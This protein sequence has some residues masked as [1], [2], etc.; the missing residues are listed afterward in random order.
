MNSMKHYLPLLIFLLVFTRLSILHAEESTDPALIPPKI[1]RP[2]PD[3]YGDNQRM[4]QGIPSVTRSAG[5]RLWATWYTGGTT[6][7]HLNYVLL[8]TSGDDGETWRE[9]LLAVDPDGSGPIRAFDPA[10][11]TDP[12]GRVWLFWAQGASW[13]DGRGGVWAM[14]CDEPERADAQWS[15]PRRLCDGIMMCRPIVDSKGRWLFPATV[16][17]I[18]PNSIASLAHDMG[19]LDGAN[20]MVS[21][22]EGKTLSLLGQARTPAGQNTFNEHMLVERKDGSFWML[23]R[24]KYGIG[25]AT[26]T[27]GG[28]TWSDVTPSALA[29][30]SARFFIHRLNSG[31]LLLVKHGRIK[32]RIGRSHLTAYLS[33][34]EGKTWP[35]SLML[36]ERTGVSYP[37]GVQD[38]DG[39][40]FVIYDY[41]RTSAKQILMARFTEKDIIAGRLVDDSSKL[42]LLVNQATGNAPSKK[43]PLQFTPNKNADAAVM[44]KGP[45]PEIE[46]V[47]EK[48]RVMD[49]TQG[50]LLFH[51]R[52]YRAAAIPK[53]LADREFLYSGIDGTTELIC[54]RPGVLYILTPE[55][56]RNRDSVV[57]QITRQGFER[58]RLSEFLLFGN[59]VG[60]ICT[61]YQKNLKEGERVIMGKWGVAVW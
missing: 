37:D 55:R 5:G 56:S 26:S 13:W 34:D 29:H 8:T 25:E 40:I 49:L 50:V 20:I 44:L 48:D 59:I 43:T 14:T 39:R 12:T 33:D 31:R 61:V 54:R 18:S 35:H 32:E 22:D 23:L 38:E 60:N 7:N 9:P 27:D 16:W 58:V 21:T 41:S 47:S 19:D 45:R 1:L 6:E 15:K 36:D 30:P 57:E 24:T 11:W 10:M 53:E 42:R 28:K 52:T 46:T 51:D 3:K 4:F 2:V 17:Q